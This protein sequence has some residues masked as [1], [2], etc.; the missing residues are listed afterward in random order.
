MK[1]WQF[2]WRSQLYKI[3]TMTISKWLLC[4]EC[5]WLY[6]SY[7][8]STIGIHLSSMWRAVSVH[9]ARVRVLGTMGYRTDMS[10]GLKKVINQWSTHYTYHPKKYSI[11]NLNTEGKGTRNSFASFNRFLVDSSWFSI[12]EIML[13]VLIPSQSGCFYLMFLPN[14]PS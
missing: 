11:F 9:K 10:P 7:F 2:I 3:L 4:G 12:Y 6:F 1:L 14:W 5:N 8:F 13:I